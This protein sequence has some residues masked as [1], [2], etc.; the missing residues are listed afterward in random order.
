MIS[1]PREPRTFVQA[2]RDFLRHGDF[3]TIWQLPYLL[4][5]E[6]GLSAGEV[7]VGVEAGPV[8]RIEA[9]DNTR[10]RRL[11]AELA[12]ELGPDRVPMVDGVGGRLRV[13]IAPAAG[14]LWADYVRGRAAAG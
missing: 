12:D 2:L 13:D 11:V 10:L 9:A 1:P 4:A 3:D 5:D 6:A 14:E 7:L 8:V